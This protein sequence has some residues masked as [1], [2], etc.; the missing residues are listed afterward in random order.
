LVEGKKKIL[1]VRIPKD[2]QDKLFKDPKNRDVLLAKKYKAEIQFEQ[3]VR[4][5]YGDDPLDFEMYA[6]A[7]GAKILKVTKL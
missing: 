2:E 1:D 6:K 7:N 3:K 5:L 4:F